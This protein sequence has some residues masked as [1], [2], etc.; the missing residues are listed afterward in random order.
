MIV[1]GVLLVRVVRAQVWTPTVPITAMSRCDPCKQPSSAC[2]LNAV[3]FSELFVYIHM[4]R[5]PSGSVFYFV[6]FPGELNPGFT[7]GMLVTTA[8]ILVAWHRPICSVI[9]IPRSLASKQ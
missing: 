8:G 1:R 3:H 2:D 7:V 9:V 4:V 5:R 6:E